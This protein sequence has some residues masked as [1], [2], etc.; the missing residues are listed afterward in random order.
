M[1]EWAGLHSKSQMHKNQQNKKKKHEE[2]T[3]REEKKQPDTVKS[4]QVLSQT[5]PY[6][7]R[8]MMIQHFI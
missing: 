4:K 5:N 2:E 3:K 1:S 7:S 6:K 8:T